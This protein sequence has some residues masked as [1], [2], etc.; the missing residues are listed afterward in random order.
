MLYDFYNTLSGK[1]KCVVP[2]FRVLAR[3]LISHA[4]DNAIT[5]YALNSAQT[6]F[7]S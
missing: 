4:A 3:I 5:K 7:Y 1:G 6:L 2:L